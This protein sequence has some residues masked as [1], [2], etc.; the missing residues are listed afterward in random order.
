VW[1]FLAGRWP[2][3][4][5][6]PTQLASVSVAHAPRALACSAD[7]A[8][9]VAGAWG[10]NADNEE[11]GPSELYVVDVGK[12]SVTAT[13]QA[14]GVVR[15]LAFSPDG[16]WFAVATI[17]STWRPA[18]DKPDA[19]DE[20]K[21]P[22][23]ASAAVLVVFDVPAFTAKFTAKASRPETGFTD[24]AWTADSKALYAIDG[25]EDSGEVRHWDVPAFTE[26][27]AFGNLKPGPYGTLAVA[28]DGRTLAISE[29]NPRLIRLFDIGKQGETFRFATEPSD[30]NVHR[31]GFTP[32]GKAIGVLARSGVVWRDVVTGRPTKP[33]QARFVI[34]PAALNKL[35]QPPVLSP[36]GS[37]HA[38]GYAVHRG[39]GDLGWDTRQ[40]EFGSFIRVVDN[41]SEKTW[42]WRV[43]NAQGGEDEPPVAFFPDGTKLAGAVREPNGGSIRIWSVPK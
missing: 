35:P 25:L 8:H 9:L 24:L 36:D 38:R 33:G 11:A 31:L 1:S 6:M 20:A 18:A 29:S 17:Y 12:A 40:N 23:A 13:L 42:S 21:P 43:G 16:K 7:G 15:G 3:Q 5:D 27:P 10:W 32:D 2:G 37:K 19:D 28:P 41:S 26:Q 14:T 39:F 22:P 4:L 34:E 30:L